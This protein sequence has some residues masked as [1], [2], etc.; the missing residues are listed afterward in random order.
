[1]QRPVLK[2]K[3]K[4]MIVRRINPDDLKVIKYDGTN[5][6]DVKKFL[7]RECIRTV[8]KEGEHDGCLC[9]DLDDG[10]TLFLHE[11]IYIVQNIN[12]WGWKDGFTTCD[13]L[14]ELKERFVIVK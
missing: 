3:C 4:G 6:D 10:Y 2:D 5:L 11:G 9:L 14:E 7:K 1:M 12:Y 8:L 13:S